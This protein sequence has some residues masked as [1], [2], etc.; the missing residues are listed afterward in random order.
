MNLSILLATVLAFQQ[1]DAERQYQLDRTLLIN[2]CE[3]DLKFEG[4]DIEQVEFYIGGKIARQNEFRES[5]RRFVKEEELYSWDLNM[6]THESSWYVYHYNLLSSIKN[7]YQQAKSMPKVGDSYFLPK[8]EISHELYLIAGNYYRNCKEINESFLGFNANQF[9]EY[10]KEAADRM[11]IWSLIYEAS[12]SSIVDY[13]RRYC[14][15]ILI[16]KIGL[17]NF[18]L[19]NFPSAIP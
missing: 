6:I 8:R 13:R 19:G 17:E 7:F 3:N 4:D 14:M 15:S 12:N 18:Y 11:E 9:K 10:V 1:A 5:V 16:E 2:Y